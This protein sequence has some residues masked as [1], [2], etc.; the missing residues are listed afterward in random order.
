[1]RALQQRLEAAASHAGL[2]EDGGA[3]LRRKSAELGT[4]LAQRDV[5]IR[6]LEERLRSLQVGGGQGSLLLSQLETNCRHIW[7]LWPWR[8]G[9]LLRTVSRMRSRHSLVPAS[10][11]HPPVQ[12][13]QGSEGSRE[14]QLDALQSGGEALRRENGTLRQ[15]VAALEVSAAAV[16][17]PSH[18]PSARENLLVR[19]VA[20]CACRM[21]HFDRVPGRAAL[22][23]DK[24]RLEEALRIARTQ[25]SA[26]QCRNAELAAEAARAAAAAAGAAA[27]PVLDLRINGSTAHA[28]GSGA[29]YEPV[30]QPALN[31]SPQHHQQHGAEPGW[32][33]ATR[34]ATPS[35]MPAHHQFMAPQYPEQQALP[36]PQNSLQH[37]V[38]ADESAWQQA[39]QG[40]DT[41]QRPRTAAGGPASNSQG[42]PT[43]SA[44]QQYNQHAATPEDPAAKWFSG[45]VDVAGQPAYAPVADASDA[46]SVSSYAAS[47][48][49]P[50]P[51]PWQLQN[52]YGSSSV[53]SAMHLAPPAP[54]QGALQQLPPQAGVAPAG[55]PL[56]WQLQNDYGSSCVTH[57]RHAGPPSAGEP[58]QSQHLP[59]ATRTSSEG[60]SARSDAGA[61]SI[62][63]R[64]GALSVGGGTP[65]P[66]GSP[67]ATEVTL[68]VGKSWLQRSRRHMQAHHALIFHAVL[69]GRPGRPALLPCLAACCK[70]HALWPQPALTMTPNHHHR[71]A[72]QDMLARTQA[73]EDRLLALNA[74]RNE[75]QA[76]SARM[77]SHTT[78][79]TLQVGAAPVPRLAGRCCAQG[80]LMACCVLSL[81]LGFCAS[82]WGTGFA[83]P[84]DIVDA[85][86]TSRY[87]SCQERKRR[88]EVERRLEELN[89]ECSS[90]RLQLRRLGVK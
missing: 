76:E 33:P 48:R 88:A 82:G 73:L 23:G 21:H 2:L 51:Q 69:P 46:C 41:Q 78:G 86:C 71:I 4:T 47:A 20:W 29:R 44:L 26:L 9:R 56:P 16:V 3:A 7:Q 15:Q 27:A 75:L 60:G 84:S 28:N 67:F 74:E 25:V 17:W 42:A 81:V 57:N 53:T 85:S 89:R 1:M 70:G 22:Q 52:D 8:A 59:A 64:L 31:P 11:R 38:N 43:P 35:A 5:T 90:V 6:Q 12:R 58:A 37:S 49:G 14:R 32:A 50:W 61:D 13:M 19:H 39:R 55:S 80:S 79:R 30:A 24:Q 36:D 65:G 72:L 62:G 87:S 18:I 34:Q 40:L 63:A 83:L 10:L 45:S 77:P 54:R 66:A 68:Q